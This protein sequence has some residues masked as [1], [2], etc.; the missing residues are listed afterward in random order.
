MGH[1]IGGTLHMAVLG[2]LL[3]GSLPGIIIASRIAPKVPDNALRIVLA[4]TLLL[5]SFQLLR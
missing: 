3:L 2:S 4:S 1:L 5:V